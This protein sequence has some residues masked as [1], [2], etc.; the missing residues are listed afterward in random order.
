LAETPGP[1]LIWTPA[2]LWL[3]FWTPDGEQRRSVGDV[4]L[5]RAKA[6][7]KGFRLRL[8]VRGDE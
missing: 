8:E 1:Y 4:P 6:M 5:W 3:C 7:A 2:E